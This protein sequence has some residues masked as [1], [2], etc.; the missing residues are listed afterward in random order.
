MLATNCTSFTVAADFVIYTTSAHLAHFLP[1][2]SLRPRLAAVE[3]AT[4]EQ[5]FVPTPVEEGETRRI[6]RGARIV[7][8]VPSAS[9]LVLQMP[10]GNLET[11]CPR[12]L[13]MA[14]VRRDI[15]AGKWREAFIACRKH[16]VE[17][18]VLVQEDKTR[19]MD[20]VPEFVSQVEEVDYLNLF[21]TSIGCVSCLRPFSGSPD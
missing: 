15:A 2:S 16:R 6:E 14:V 12:A 19:F 20:S 10:R 9:A 21:L 3:R 1:L 4:K 17:L 11:I 5:D 8:A 13:V 7:C 18:A